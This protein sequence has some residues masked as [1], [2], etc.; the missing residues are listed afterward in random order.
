M[1]NYEK[2]Y[3][4]KILKYSKSKQCKIILHG[5]FLV[6]RSD[7]L[8]QYHH[9][10]DVVLSSRE[11]TQFPSNSSRMCIERAKEL[12]VQDILPQAQVYSS[13]V[14]SYHP[15][16]K[17]ICTGIWRRSLSQDWGGASRYVFHRGWGK[18][19]TKTYNT[20]SWGS[21]FRINRK[22][23]FQSTMLLIDLLQQS[24]EVYHIG[25]L[26]S[27]LFEVSQMFNIFLICDEK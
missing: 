14:F 7:V 16:Q 5:V 13:T 26:K 24:Q 2:C 3:R 19:F 27:I 17:H 15:T 12:W 21:L 8:I 4:L 9:S 10:L 6:K 20:L 22:E 11:Q 23:V 25:K 18:D 1:R